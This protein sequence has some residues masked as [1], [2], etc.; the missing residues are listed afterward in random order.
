VQAAAQQTETELKSLFVQAQ[1]GND[2]AY[3][4]FLQRMSGVLRA[5]FRKR[6]QRD[7]S[8]VE[9]LV[10]EV[11][12]ALHN[13]RH[14]YDAA[15]PV[16]AWAHG[17]ARYKLIDH[18]R[19]RNRAEHIDIEDAEDLLVTEDHEVQDARRD[20]STLLEEL[21]DKQKQVILLV[22]VQGLSV[23]EASQTTGQSESLV[24]VNVHRGLKKLAQLIAASK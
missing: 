22:K 10:Q 6:L 15:Y 18:Y 8:E 20:L 11:L 13:Q 16:T 2:K 5:Y 4:T 21:P 24:K 1:V 7:P 23:A 12:I 14:T 17:I 3:N 9:D 19:R